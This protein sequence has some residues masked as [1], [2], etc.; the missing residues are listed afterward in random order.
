[1]RESSSRASGLFDRP[2]DGL[3]FDEN[4]R[5]AQRGAKKNEV[6]KKLSCVTLQKARRGLPWHDLGQ[7]ATQRRY[8]H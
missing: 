5:T 6:A 8:A 3:N 2:A 4:D 7:S 1:M